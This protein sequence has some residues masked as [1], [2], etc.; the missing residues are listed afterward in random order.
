MK[1]HTILLSKTRK[2]VEN[3]SFAAVVIGALSLNTSEKLLY[4]S[5]ISLGLPEYSEKA[6]KKGVGVD[7]WP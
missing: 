2:D 3:L 5:C 4:C 1:Y 7:I 6:V